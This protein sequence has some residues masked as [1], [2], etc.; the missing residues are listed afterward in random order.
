MRKI[1]RQREQENVQKKSGN[2][3]QTTI[4]SKSNQKHNSDG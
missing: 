3:I 4:S 1:K 2:E